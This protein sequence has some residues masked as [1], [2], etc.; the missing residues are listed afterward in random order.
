MIEIRQ[1]LVRKTTSLMC[2]LKSQH[3]NDL[4]KTAGTKPGVMVPEMFSFW[5]S[6]E[7]IVSDDVG[8]SSVRHDL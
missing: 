3:R 8:V 6:T 7:V 5:F 2:F 4:E 1:V